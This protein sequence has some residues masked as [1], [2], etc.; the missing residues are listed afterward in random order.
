M[1]DASTTTASTTTTT[2]EAQPFWS[3]FDDETK[4]YVQAKGLATKPINEAFLQVSKFHREAEKMIGAPA[5]ELLRIPKDQTSPEWANVYKRL[6]ALPTP[7]DY[8][9]DALKHSGDKPLNE[10]LVAT[11]RK[12]AH[13]AHLSNDSATAFAKEIVT[14]LDGIETARVA[15]ETAKIQTEKKAL[16]DNWGAN[17]AA[18]MVVARSAALALG[19]TPEVVA[20]L[21][22]TLGYSKVMELFRTIGTK[23]GEDRFVSPN[24]QG[25]SGVMTKEQALAEKTALKNDQAWV[26]RFLNGGI[27][28]RRKMEAL[29]K[30]ITGVAA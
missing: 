14:H 17:E 16:K 27:E 8:K 11:L 15:D 9:F 28:E 30:I 6:G 29:D 5:N 13:A 24:G 4:G 12:A 2:T 7:D 19:V 20:A 23:I 3:G 1:T 10:G 22:K 21:E 18:N 26:K 25:G